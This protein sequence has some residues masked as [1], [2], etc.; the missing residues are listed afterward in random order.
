MAITIAK[1]AS[2]L[3][4]AGAL[5]LGSAAAQE[6]PEALA[7]AFCAAVIDED[8]EALAALYTDDADS[9]GP[10]GD[11]AKGR[12]AIAAGWTPFFDVFEE[13]TCELTEAGALIEDDMAAVWGLWVMTGAPTGGGDTIVMEG[14]Y[15]D[16]LVKKN[17]GWRY[18]VDHASMAAP[19]TPPAE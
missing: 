18:R 8:I 16:V 5:L 9:Y 4:G 17:D 12:D 15:T 7:A 11:V 19:A 3:A 2:T 6:S 1:T 14:R 10:G 13:L